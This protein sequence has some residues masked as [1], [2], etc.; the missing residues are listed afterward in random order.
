[1]REFL[2]QEIVDE[3]DKAK[4]AA[5]IEKCSKRLYDIRDDVRVFVKC[6]L[7]MEE[8]EKACPDH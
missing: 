1:M 5:S 3:K 6:T 4:F 8:W 2:M 7:I